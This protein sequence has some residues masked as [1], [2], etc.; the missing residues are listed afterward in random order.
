V[1]DRA[2]VWSNKQVQA[3]AEKFIPVAVEV[4]QLIAA[5]NEFGDMFRK[6]AEEGHY[7]KVSGG[8]RQGTYMLTPAGRLLSSGNRQKPESTLE[9]MQQALAEWEK[10]PR[11]ERLPAQLPAADARALPKS[12]FPEDGLSLYVS[13]RKFFP[14]PLRDEPV[15]ARVIATS[16]IPPRL[17]AFARNKPETY[18]EVEWN[19][20]HAWF[21]REEARRLLPERLTPGAAGKA[22]PA[23]VARLAR[24]HMLD[25]VRALADVYSPEHVKDTTLS[26]NIVAVTG[27]VAEVRFTGSVRILQTGMEAFART[28]DQTSPV[29]KKPE[30]GYDATLLGRA[31]YDRKR[32]RFIAFELV[33]LGEKTGGSKLSPFDK[34]TMGVS[35][36]LSPPDAEEPIEPRYLSQYGWK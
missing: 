23:L 21:T 33:A 7:G 18:W 12:K 2:V 8:T 19:Q 34:T 25:T 9:L 31:K 5:Q 27:D 26:A 15:D 28:V 10:L 17:A 30:R 32:E 20:D 36:T 13:L 6:I 1:Q 22:D 3:E 29:P 11:A 16:G 14:R 4:S 35:F 24:L